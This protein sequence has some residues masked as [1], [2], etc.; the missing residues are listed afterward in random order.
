MTTPATAT[1]PD[2]L[3]DTSQLT[4]KRMIADHFSRLARAGKTGDKC[5]YTFVPGNLTDEQLVN[6]T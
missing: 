6:I 5:V 4:Q 3:K 2:A 1:V